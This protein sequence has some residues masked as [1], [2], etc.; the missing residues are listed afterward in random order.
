VKTIRLFFCALAAGPICLAACGGDDSR[1]TTST[2]SGSGGAAGGGT[3]STSTGASGSSSGAGGRDA[4]ATTGSAGSGGF[5]ASGGTTGNGGTGG[6]AGGGGQSDL[7]ASIADAMPDAPATRDAPMDGRISLFDGQTLAGWD[8]MPGIWSVKDGAIDGASN[9]TSQFPGTFLVSRGDFSNFRLLLTERVVVSNDHLGVCMWG[10]RLAAGNWGAGKCLVVIP[11]DGS[12]W[13]YGSGGIHGAKVGNAG[14][15][16]HTWHQIEIV[17]HRDTGEILMAVNG[18]QVTRY[19]DAN[20]SRL[21]NGPIR[22][23]LHA[24][25][26]AQEVQ[27]KDIVIEPNPADYRLV[28]L[29]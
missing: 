12:M 2:V 9:T 16:S 24:W 1:G 20:P 13:D 28:T 14:V 11:P 21:P 23:Q 17:A 15:D 6:V 19:K 4:A 5:M 22:L 3:D 29:K 27:Y 7:D 26:G 8:G 10:N 25:T 18:T